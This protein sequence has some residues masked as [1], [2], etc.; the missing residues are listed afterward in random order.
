MVTVEVLSSKL[1]KNERGFRQSKKRQPDLIESL[2]KDA[3]AT[4]IQART[5][6]II[7]RKIF[8]CSEKVSIGC[9]VEEI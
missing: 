8:W 5:R 3:A 9:Q 1:L 6:G 4:L 7:I 2:A